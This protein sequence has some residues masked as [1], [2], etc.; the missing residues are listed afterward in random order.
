MRHASREDL[1]QHVAGPF[2]RHRLE[3]LGRVT[4]R[5]H[6]V[7]DRGCTLERAAAEGAR[8]GR[9]LALPGHVEAARRR[10]LGDL[11]ERGD[12]V[13]ATCHEHE[14]REVPVGRRQVD[15]AGG[16]L[17]AQEPVRDLEHDPGTVARRGVR[18]RRTAVLQPLEHRQR[19]VDEAVAGGAVLVDEQAHAA[20]IVLEGRVV[21][22]RA[23]S[24]GT[25]S[26][27]QGPCAGLTGGVLVV[28]A[29]RVPASGVAIE[30]STP[31]PAPPEK[32]EL[33]A[34]DRD[35]TASGGVDGYVPVDGSP[36][37]LRWG[38]T[39][40]TPN[41]GWRWTRARRGAPRKAALLDRTG[42]TCS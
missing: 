1:A 31:V 41:G 12:G 26:R 18:P 23:P 14:S 19:L 16:G 7:V 32:D 35:A 10:H 6:H 8:V 29:R 39:D 33:D 5:E 37:R 20:G 38:C 11:A 36:W 2:E 24:G 3:R 27:G 9:H 22:A 25:W 4:S 15:A 34:V 21:E 42:P 28:R 17:R 13:V 40:W 30:Q